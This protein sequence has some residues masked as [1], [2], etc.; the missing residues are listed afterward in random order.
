MTQSDLFKNF[1]AEIHQDLKSEIVADIVERIKLQAPPSLDKL[2]ELRDGDHGD[3]R[4]QADCAKFIL[5]ELHMD[6]VYPKATRMEVQHETKVVISDEAFNRMLD[7]LGENREI[8][9]VTPPPT[10][11]EVIE[12]LKIEEAAASA[13]AGGA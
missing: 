6:R 11:D 10:A 9:D 2:I 5:G 3:L 12:Q 13:G 7:V 1:A 4:L 8:I